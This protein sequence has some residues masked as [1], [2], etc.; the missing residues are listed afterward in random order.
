[1]TDETND[2]SHREQTAEE[3]QAQIAIG[4]DTPGAVHCCDG[5]WRLDTPE[6]AAIRATK[7]HAT[8][9]PEKFAFNGLPYN[10]AWRKGVQNHISRRM[11][12]AI[13][14]A[15]ELIGREKLR[16][17]LKSKRQEDHDYVD[18][19]VTIADGTDLTPNVVAFFMDLYK[20]EPRVFGALIG[21]LLPL[22]ISGPND[23]P[24]NVT[25]ATREEIISN[26]KRLGMPLPDYLRDAEDAR[27]ID[28]KVIEDKTDERGD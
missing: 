5:V 6:Q 22:Q 21:R 1:M 4:P 12:E 8:R 19:C 27:V 26:Y 23:G 9:H 20:E 17:K 16:A 14:A 3:V 24:I 11:R 10:R 15:T 18:Q 28:G 25:A 7:I 2:D 13:A